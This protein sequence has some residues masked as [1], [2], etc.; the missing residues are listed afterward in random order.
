MAL[1]PFLIE[2]SEIIAYL[3]LLGI[4]LLQISIASIF[5]IVIGYKCQSLGVRTHLIVCLATA[6]I[7]VVS[8]YG[9]NIILNYGKVAL[10]FYKLL[11]KLFFV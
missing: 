9:F 4:Y 7:M 5:E 10:I 11:L 6:M 8:K 1:G 3:L 2:K